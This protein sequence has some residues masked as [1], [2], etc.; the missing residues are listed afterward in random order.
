MLVKYLIS[1][2][3][4]TAGATA[5]LPDSLAYR[6]IVKGKAEKAAETAIKVKTGKDTAKTD[7]PRRIARNRA[8]NAE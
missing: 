8:K 5:S 4:I 7:K 3:G 1:E 2:C 6:L